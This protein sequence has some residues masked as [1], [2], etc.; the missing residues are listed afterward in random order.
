MASSPV[1]NWSDTTVVEYK[2]TRWDHQL[3][4][5]HGVLTEAYQTSHGQF[6][7]LN[8]GSREETKKL[9]T[10]T[11]VGLKREVLTK[12][13]ELRAASGQAIRD[14]PTIA[15]TAV[16]ASSGA[17]EQKR[18]AALKEAARSFRKM[19]RLLTEQ[20]EDIEDLAEVS[21]LL[22][23]ADA[24]PVN[25]PA[26]AAGAEPD[27]DDVQ[28]EKQLGAGSSAA[29]TPIAEEAITNCAVCLKPVKGQRGLKSHQR[30][31]RG[32]P[33]ADPAADSKRR[34]KTGA[35]EAEVA[36]DEEASKAADP[37]VVAEEEASKAA[38]PVAGADEDA[39]AGHKRRRRR[40]R[41]HGADEA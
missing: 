35:D 7:K 24:A 26:V 13:L 6:T 29:A 4:K 22:G 27:S 31:C 9:V 25:A 1:G 20:G 23:A 36:A 21:K 12:L 15:G 17:A 32:A 5:A 33:A 16:A 11:Y 37:V 8:K 28:G 3:L 10:A 40:R 38:D 18:Q 34:R 30:H 19:Q 39:V 2:V 14:D 41:N